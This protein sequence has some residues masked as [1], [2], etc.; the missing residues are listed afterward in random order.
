MLLG[1]MHNEVFCFDTS[2]R[3]LT[4][5]AVNQLRAPG[6][7]RVKAHAK[8]SSTLNVHAYN[9]IESRSERW[10][11]GCRR[12]QRAK[13]YAYANKFFQSRNLPTSAECRFAVAAAQ[14]LERV[15]VATIRGGVFRSL[16]ARRTNRSGGCRKLLSDDRMPLVVEIAQ[17]R[18]GGAAASL[19]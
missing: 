13:N 1:H 12:T 8:L 16:S 18:S 4:L 5:L 2:P 11:T 14:H 15:Q 19:C 10:H 3:L 17:D 6:T 7:N 9:A